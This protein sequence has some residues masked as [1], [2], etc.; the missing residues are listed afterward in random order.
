MTDHLNDAHN[1][2]LSKSAAQPASGDK[3][4]VPQISPG[5]TEK[6]IQK[7]TRKQTFKEL[8]FVFAVGFKNIVSG[9]FKIETIQDYDKK[10]K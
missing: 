8:L 4:P 10:R 3:K 1:D 9:F 6:V 7:A 5:F 2:G